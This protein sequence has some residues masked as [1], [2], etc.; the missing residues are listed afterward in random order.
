MNTSNKFS[1]LQGDDDGHDLN[2]TLTDGDDHDP[3][4]IP[5]PSHVGKNIPMHATLKLETCKHGTTT[6]T[7]N[8]N[9]LYNM[10]HE[11]KVTID[12]GSR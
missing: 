4:P 9:N 10:C 11:C 8:N 6:T 12:L 5:K 1:L 3:F 7:I 2:G